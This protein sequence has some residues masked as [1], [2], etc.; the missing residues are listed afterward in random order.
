MKKKIALIFG[1]T[2][3]DGSYLAKF[4]IKKNYKI[5]GITRNLNKKNLFRLQKL[6]IEKKIKIIKSKFLKK[7]F[8]KNKKINE[9]YFLA[10]E[11]SPLKSEIN[12]IET[13]NSNLISLINILEFLKKNKSK[14]RLF[15]ASSSEI[16]KKKNKNIFS[17]VSEIE[18]RSPYGISKAASLWIVK[19]YRSKFGIYCCSGILFNHESPLRSKNFVFK[20]IVD[21]AKKLK[22]NGGKLNLGNINIKRDIGWAPDYVKAMW[23]MLQ[24]K[25]PLDLVI[26][27]GKM[28][29]IKDF[30]NLTLKK[31]KLDKNKIIVNN[32]NLIRFNDIKAY[33]S[34]P[35][36]ANKK[37]KWKNSLNLNEIVNKMINNDYL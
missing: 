10:G 24:Q 36:L 20:K 1:I 27:S 25:K 30:L 16:F 15:Y 2:G 21:E 14:A 34:N 11:T 22:K 6:N 32:K 7:I 4:L 28:Y 8:Y 26:G 13:F 23:K 17:E 9:I 12:P 35:S 31:L 29:S 37:L 3:Q 5:I 18:P 19:F 33:R